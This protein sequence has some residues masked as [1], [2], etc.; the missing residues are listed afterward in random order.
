[1]KPARSFLTDA[2]ARSRGIDTSSISS[3]DLERLAELHRE[4]IG[5]F[6]ALPADVRQAVT[7]H[8]ARRGET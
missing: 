6:Y 5:A 2:L 1:M 4:N 8:E 3:D 7:D